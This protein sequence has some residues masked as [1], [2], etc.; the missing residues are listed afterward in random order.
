M[1]SHEYKCVF[2][3]IPKCAGTSIE[4]VLGHFDNLNLDGRGLQ[5]HR[6]VRMIEQPSLSLRTFSS[7]ENAC[8][9]LRRIRHNFHTEPN[10]RNKYA[11]TKV[12]YSRYFKF[13][14]VRNPWSRAYSCYNNIMH[15]AI[16][17]KSLGITEDLSFRKFLQL[18]VGK[19]W[20]RPQTY[21]LKN[22]RGELPFDYIGYF[23]T[24]SHDFKEI[25]AAM[26]CTSITL[27]H[28][29]KGP[30]GDY[31]EQYDQDSIDL[32]SRVYREEIALFGYSFER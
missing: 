3:H 17:R 18:Y 5:D 4:R 11:V 2:I 6:T 15:D 28:K 7:R 21:W 24:L 27:P 29:L 1:I 25:C 26:H 13:T 16:H 32:I 30:P 9:Y 14:I 20:L 22:F 8:E 23:E 10:P 19:G 12:Q 31:R